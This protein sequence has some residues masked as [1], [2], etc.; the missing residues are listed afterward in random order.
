MLGGRIATP[1]RRAMG[2]PL[3]TGQPVSEDSLFHDGLFEEVCEILRNK[4]EARVVRDIS[5]LIT[6]SAETIAVRDSK[7]QDFDRK[8]Q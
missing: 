4:N 6:P 7:H 2:S 8:C 1:P 3:Q 5:P